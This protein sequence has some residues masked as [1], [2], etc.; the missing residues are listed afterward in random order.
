METI[1]TDANYKL[2]INRIA[3][4]SS[5]QMLTPNEAEE[6]GKLSK[7]AMAY[8]Y[9]KYDFVLSNLLKNQLFQPSIVV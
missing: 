8:E 5:M 1:L 2:T 6:L 7:M 3:L 9:R 4:L